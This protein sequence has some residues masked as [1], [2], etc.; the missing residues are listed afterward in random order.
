MSPSLY[1]RSL[2]LCVFCK[3]S[4]WLLSSVPHPDSISVIMSALGLWL[5]AVRFLRFMSVSKRRW[6]ICDSRWEAGTP[7]TA[8]NDTSWTISRLCLFEVFAEHSSARSP[9]KW[10]DPLR[11]TFVLEQALQTADYSTSQSFESIL[12]SMDKLD[13]PVSY[14]VGVVLFLINSHSIC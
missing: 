13:K 11:D 6:L 1:Q 9:N 5:S 3:S 8:G 10:K 4:C 14:K 2:E 7:A 12:G